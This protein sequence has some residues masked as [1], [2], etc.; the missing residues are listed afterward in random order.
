MKRRLRKK[1]KLKEFTDYGFPIRINLLEEDLKLVFLYEYLTFVGNNK[2]CSG[3]TG[4]YNVMNHYIIGDKD[5]WTKLEAERGK[6]ILD[7]W[8]KNH[9]KIKSYKIGNINNC[10][11]I[12]NDVWNDF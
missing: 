12:K 11:D 8:L 9:T 7:N 10:N 5:I 2:M 6:Q 4:G 3:G 1:L